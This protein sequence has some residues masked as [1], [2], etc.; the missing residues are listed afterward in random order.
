V[1]HLDDGSVEWLGEHPK[2]DELIG[3]GDA[4]PPEKHETAEKHDAASAEAGKEAGPHDKDEAH[5]GD[6]PHDEAEEHAQA[7]VPPPN[8]LSFAIVAAIACMAG[9]ISMKLSSRE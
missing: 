3:A 9:A 4:A 2:Q 6:A 8:P 1:Y 5:A 7:K